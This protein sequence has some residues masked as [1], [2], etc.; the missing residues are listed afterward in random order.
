MSPGTGTSVDEPRDGHNPCG[1]L[2][3][4]HPGDQSRRG[5][6]R[7]THKLS[8]YFRRPTTN[9]PGPPTLMPLMSGSSIRPRTS[10]T[11]GT[12]KTGGETGDPHHH[13]QTHRPA[14][15]VPGHTRRSQLHHH[16]IRH[17]ELRLG[18]ERTST[19]LPVLPERRV[20]RLPATILVCLSRFELPLRRWQRRVLG[21]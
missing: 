15:E 13:R 11:T 19:P 21:H 3:H 14:R 4:D 6:T 16:Q 7:G 12:N 20:H 5:T 8:F 17:P 18:M 1:S 9:G 10:G 2:T